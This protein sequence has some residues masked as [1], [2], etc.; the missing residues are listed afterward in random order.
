MAMFSAA[1]Q[2]GDPVD[3]ESALTTRILRAPYQA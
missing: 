1:G 2:M 3:G